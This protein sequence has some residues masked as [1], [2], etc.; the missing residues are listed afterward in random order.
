[1][2]NIGKSK[3]TRIRNSAGMALVV[4]MMVLM[5]ATMIA[6][7]VTTDSTIDI[8]IA[9]NQ[10][11]YTK[12]FFIVEAANQV[13][14]PRISTELAVHNINVRT[15]LNDNTV[16]ILTGLP[17]NPSYRSTII[18]HRYGPPP[19]G[20]SL[21]KFSSYYYSTTTSKKTRIRTTEGK[22]GTKF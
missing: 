8:K 9:G 21:D 19:P 5:V 11:V 20:Y 4:V 14:V 16:E 13:E 1:M 22:I 17:G 6:I 3:D 2:K 18:Y 10:K 7:G 15:T 12:N